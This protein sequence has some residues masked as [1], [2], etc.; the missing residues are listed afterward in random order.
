MDISEDQFSSPPNTPSNHRTRGMPINPFRSLGVPYPLLARSRLSTSRPAPARPPPRQR[1]IAEPPRRQSRPHGLYSV[2]VPAPSSSTRTRQ[3][4]CRTPRPPSSTCPAPRPPST[5]P[6]RSPRSS[7]THHAATT[8]VPASPGGRGT[9]GSRGRPRP[10]PPRCNDNGTPHASLIATARRSRCRT[11]RRQRGHRMLEG[12]PLADHALRRWGGGPPP[13]LRAAGRAGGP[14][15]PISE[16]DGLP[17]ERPAGMVGSLTAVGKSMGPRSAASER[18]SSE[19]TA[20]GDRLPGKYS[21]KQRW[22]GSDG[23][24]STRMA[25]DRWQRKM[26]RRAS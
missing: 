3:P 15:G 25:A 14:P 26:S 22:K 13:P 6:P 24:S 11:D 1:G 10:G 16:P 12:R 8:R 18:K 7:F 9:R 4:P 17:V 20:S 2:S 21:P 19:L 23:S 5:T